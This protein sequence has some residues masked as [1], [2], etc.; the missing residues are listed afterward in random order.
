MPAPHATLLPCRVRPLGVGRGVEGKSDPSCSFAWIRPSGLRVWDPR[1]QPRGRVRGRKGPRGRGRGRGR[2]REPRAPL[3]H[4]LKGPAGPC[5]RGW[6]HPPG[7]ER[8]RASARRRGGRAG[9]WPP[10]PPS[11]APRPP[12]AVRRPQSPALPRPPAPPPS[13]RRLPFRPSPCRP[14][15]FPGSALHRAA[16][17]PEGTEAGGQPQAAAGAGRPVQRSLRMAPPP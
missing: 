10:W 12:P 7:R 5:G 9:G 6:P 17:P 1:I 2:V 11:S 15:P 14:S 4:V 13:P 8:V 16:P 3:P